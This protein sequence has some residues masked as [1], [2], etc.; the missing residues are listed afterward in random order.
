MGV[1]EQNLKIDF[2]TG[3]TLHWVKQR[4]LMMKF[5][6]STLHNLCDDLTMFCKYMRIIFSF[7]VLPGLITH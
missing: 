4:K 1:G 3:D 6:F 7:F 2:N 5:S